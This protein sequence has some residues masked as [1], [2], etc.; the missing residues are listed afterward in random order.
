MVEPWYLK[1]FLR[2]GFDGFEWL[3]ESRKGWKRCRGG[4]SWH[5]R[6]R[7]GR[8]R[9]WH[10]WNRCTA[11]VGRGDAGRLL[12]IVS[13][14]GIELTVIIAGRVVRAGHD[15]SI[16]AGPDATPNFRRRFPDKGTEVAGGT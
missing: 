16:T 2:R 12:A 8:S 10:P 14:L 4:G 9:A 7:H 6:L 1:L 5:G 3:W 15:I 13:Y 11:A